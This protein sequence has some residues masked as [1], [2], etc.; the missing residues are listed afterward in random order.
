MYFNPG[1]K[2]SNAI[3]LGSGCVLSK[4][5]EKKGMYVSQ[6]LRHI[7]NSL[8]KVKEKLKKV[9]DFKLIEPVYN[10]K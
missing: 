4:N 2:I 10:K 8:E 3:H 9:N 7:D 6:S 5:L 1:V